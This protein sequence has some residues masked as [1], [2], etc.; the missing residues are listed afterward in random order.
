MPLES[1]VSV[2]S[3]LDADPA[4]DIMCCPHDFV[5]ANNA[6]SSKALPFC[7]GQVVDIDE[8]S[9]IIQWW[10]PGLSRE[11]N[12]KAGRKKEV[13][14]IFSEWRPS[15]TFPLGELQ[16]LPASVLSPKKILLWGFQ[17]ESNQLPFSVLDKIMDLEI[18]DLT[19][20]KISS[21]KRGAMYRAHRLMRT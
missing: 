9:A 3:V 17:L 2:G 4:L 1:L 21:T 8:D 11:A 7:M 13:L 5:I 6:A 18:A 14:D 15:D 20:L 19:G 10:H 12:M 16:P